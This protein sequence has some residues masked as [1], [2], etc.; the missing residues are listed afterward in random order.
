MSEDLKSY[1]VFIA[2]PGGLTNERRAFRATL[3]EC[4]DRDAFQ[5]GLMFRAIGWEDTLAGVG[6]PQAIINDEIETCDYFLLV[7]W[8]RW[9][10]PPGGDANYT[11]GTEEEY[12]LAS[13]LLANPKKP[14]RQIVVLFKGVAEKQLS[15]PG[16]Q[17]ARV[18]GF[19]KKLEA[20]KTLL[21]GTF[22]TVEEFEQ[23]LR[24]F[25]S[26][27]P[28]NTDI[29]APVIIPSQ[30]QPRSPRNGVTSPQYSGVADLD[31]AESL[32]QSGK[33]TEAE[34]LFA[35]AVVRAE[36]SDAFSRYA[37]HLLRV[38]RLDHA[39]KYFDSAIK[40]A[41]VANN[42]ADISFAISGL[43]SIAEIRGDIHRAEDLLNRS[44][45]LNK[46]LKDNHQLA[47]NYADLAWIY[48]ERGELLRAEEFLARA[49]AL[50]AQD[51][52][53][54]GEA[55]VHD[56][57]GTVALMRGDSQKAIESIRRALAILEDLGDSGSDLA[58][59]Y[60]NLG[61]AYREAAN[62]EK[63]E[64]MHR[65]ALTIAEKLGRQEEIASELGSL[66]HVYLS[67]GDMKKAEEMYRTSLSIDEK[68][69]RQRGV[70][71]SYS[72]LGLVY[73]RNGNL[74]EAETMF[75]KSLVIE[76]TLGRK[77]GIASDC[78]NLGLVALDKKDPKAARSWWNTALETYKAIGDTENARDVE[79]LLGSLEQEESPSKNDSARDG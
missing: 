40:F 55:Q 3:N 32:A 22:D 7:L 36:N 47:N 45:A 34:E 1:S 79:Q 72:S 42:D 70:A 41:E 65:K 68:L 6:R 54:R 67:R 50:F 43:A 58:T 8:D 37:T 49:Q 10:T 46:K 26:Q 17:L 5:R 56:M 52:D 63:A 27:C 25:L 60:G 28:H 69:G 14:M 23:L 2:S 71:T 75:R 48:R 21:F 44:I 78:Y 18:L 16:E 61:N 38:G 13:Q 77:P 11:S 9:G 53:R 30:E 59:T 51:K 33:L 24:K 62:L 4:N 39:E 15:D 66:G 64:E 35:K 73:R 19:K 12:A 74:A 31:A 20:E 29:Q 76:E 57:M